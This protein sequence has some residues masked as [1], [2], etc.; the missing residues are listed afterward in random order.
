MSGNARGELRFASLGFGE[1]ALRL[2][3]VEKERLVDSLSTKAS[4]D[5]SDPEVPVFVGVEVRVVPADRVPDAPPVER[6]IR[7]L[8][9]DPQPIDGER[10]ATP[11]AGIHAEALRVG[12]GDRNAGVG[13]EHADGL[14][15]HRRR[16]AVV[17]IERQNVP[18][19]RSADSR[20]AR[21]GQPHVRLPHQAN[22]SLRVSRRE[23]LGD[24]RGVVGASVVDD[25]A[26]PVREGLGD[27]RLYGLREEARLLVT[28]DDDRYAR[29]IRVG[30]ARHARLR[31]EARW[32]GM[33]HAEI[34][35]KARPAPRAVMTAKQA[36]L[37][38]MHA[39]PRGDRRHSL[40]ARRRQPG[41]AKASSPEL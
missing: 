38:G 28:R 23:R 24:G 30:V 14:L 16:E 6:A 17:R 13:V 11:D 31:G 18:A 26:L 5:R 40:G 35:E 2:R 39:R 4:L 3:P 25:D 7:N 27:Q 41:G 1:H 34:G 19:A 22:P 12:E 10:T 20:V 29:R 15:E 21:L 9:G 33:G 8:I 36:N 32:P 37:R